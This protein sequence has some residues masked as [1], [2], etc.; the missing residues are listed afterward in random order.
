MDIVALLSRMLVL[1][2]F[3]CVGVLC[4]KLHII[5]EKGSAC[6]NQLVLYI[7][8]PLLIIK[9]VQNVQLAYG[10]RDILMLIVYSVILQLIAL[11]I[12]VVSA[13]ICCKKPIRGVFSLVTAFGNVFFMGVPVVTALY[14][15]NAVFLLSIC[16]IP[17]NLFIFTVGIYLILGSGGQ[18]IPW[19]KLLINP[20]LYATLIALPIF[21]FRIELPSTVQDIIGYLSQ[22]VVPLSMILIGASL[23]RMSL[24]RI[25]G[26]GRAYA[27][28]AFKLILIPL[29]VFAILRNIVKDP[30]ILG[31]MTVVAAMPSASISPILCAEYGGDSDFASRS[32]F[33]TTI[34][35]IV[36][37]PLMVW[38]LIGGGIKG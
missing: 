35:S 37:I 27:V 11:L 17:F 12:G 5:D 25:F 36:T 16:V 8:G 13:V 6:I 20:S 28:C 34:A 3:I 38:L 29:A 4:S 31:M 21:F 1:L 30:Q 14:G 18:K 10:V 33:L 22:M 26:N 15:D 24:K 32:V 9:S 19:K 2:V 23:G 7:C